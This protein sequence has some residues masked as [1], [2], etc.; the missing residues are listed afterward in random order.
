MTP[1]MRVATGQT[2]G[3]HLSKEVPA[4][5]SLLLTTTRMK[6]ITT[7]TL[8]EQE[9]AT[10]G[11]MMNRA[12]GRWTSKKGETYSILQIIQPAK[13]FH[14]T[15]RIIRP[16]PTDLPRLRLQGQVEPGLQY[17]YLEDPVDRPPRLREEKRGLKI[18]PSTLTL[19]GM[20]PI[21]DLT[22]LHQDQEHHLR[23]Q[24][25][26]PLHHP[27]TAPQDKGCTGANGWMKVILCR[28]S[29]QAKI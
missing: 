27:H 26:P 4:E 12:E 24:A 10:W 15:D 29:T 28:A 6:V 21:S 14:P 25:G 5:D 3:E 13:Q 1:M 17:Q 2:A 22:M 8:V 9:T 7:Q 11:A 20:N 19:T 16:K 23:D 18:C